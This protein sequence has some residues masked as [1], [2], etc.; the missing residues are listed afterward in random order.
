MHLIRGIDSKEIW[1]SSG[2]SFMGIRS[3][4]F[5]QGNWF[6]GIWSRNFGLIRGIL[7]KG[8]ALT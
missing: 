7:S 6:K 2:N 1:P 3:W 5:V 8:I 4:E